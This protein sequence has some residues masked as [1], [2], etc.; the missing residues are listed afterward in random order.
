MIKEMV[1]TTI[2]E[3]DFRRQG[4]TLERGNTSRGD[5]EIKNYFSYLHIYF[6]TYY[7][8]ITGFGTCKHCAFHTVPTQNT[9]PCIKYLGLL[10]QFQSST[11]NHKIHHHFIY[12]NIATSSNFFN[13]CQ[14]RPIL[15]TFFK[16]IQSRKCS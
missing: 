5:G 6:S 12:N 7:S 10:F 8:H 4:L 3:T 9:Q 15:M 14:C 13:H 1:L 16:E 11:R 2:G